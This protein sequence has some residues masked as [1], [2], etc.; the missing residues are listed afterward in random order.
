MFMSQGSMMGAVPLA[1]ERRFGRILI[2]ASITP[3]WHEAWGTHPATD[4]LLSTTRTRV[5][6]DGVPVRR[7]DKTVF[8]A[9]HDFALAALRVCLFTGDETNC[10]ECEKCLR[11]AITLEAMG[12][13]DRAEAFHCRSL[14]VRRIRRMAIG[15]PH[16]RH[17]YDDLRVFCR[18]QGR[19]DLAE[20]IGHALARARRHD[21]FRPLVRWLRTLPVVGPA[22]HWL[23]ARV[24]DAGV[25]R[26]RMQ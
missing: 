5:D 12:V 20:A 1:L 9:A 14:D 8:V 16:V 26:H 2:P 23:E 15:D 21:P 13:L 3:D 4:A 11:A 25:T 19:P 22:A 18:Q 17:Y 10:M 7:I 6:D 24:Q